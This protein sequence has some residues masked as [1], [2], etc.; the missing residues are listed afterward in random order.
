MSIGSHVNCLFK[1]QLTWEMSHRNETF[2]CGGVKAKAFC[3]SF[4]RPIVLQMSAMCQDQ[5][6]RHHF[7]T[8]TELQP[9]PVYQIWKWDKSIVGFYLERGNLLKG[10]L[11]LAQKSTQLSND[12]YPTLPPT[13]GWEKKKMNE[14]KEWQNLEAFCK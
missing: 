11:L 4:F 2:R 10:A 12:N 8:R 5:M 3:R 7:E 9:C 6:T 14:K 13:C 1:R